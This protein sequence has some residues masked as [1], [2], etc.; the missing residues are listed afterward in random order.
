ME[1]CKDM[2]TDAINGMRIDSLDEV[3]N[4]LGRCETIICLGNGPS[5]EDARLAG[6][7]DAI[8][9]RVNWIWTQRAWLA[10]PD[11]V[12]T[13]DPD[14]ARLPRQPI[15][16]F[17]TQ[18]IGEPILLDHAA[19]GH[20]PE[21]GYC[22]LDR[23]TPSFAD[24][25]GPRIPTNGALMIALAAALRPRRLVVSGIDLYRHP[26]GKYPGEADN[27]EGYT[28]QHS[29]DIDLDLIGRAIAGHDGE[30]VILSDNLRQALPSL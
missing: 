3:K 26:Q 9:F 13:A 22:H 2:R 25:A 14:L 7:H 24:F 5:S 21:A 19:K 28:S 1:H 16:A 23:F 30:T 12:F 15:I 20:H 17:P 10:A 4:R 18:A 27:S 6:Y 11:M 29:A 8:L